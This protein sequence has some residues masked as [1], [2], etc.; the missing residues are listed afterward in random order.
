MLHLYTLNINYFE[1][2]IDK[3]ND[4]WSGHSVSPQLPTSHRQSTTLQL[5]YSDAFLNQREHPQIWHYHF[6]LKFIHQLI[7]CYFSNDEFNDFHMSTIENDMRDYLS[8]KLQLFAIASQV[9]SLE[10]VPNEEYGI[11]KTEI[12][13]PVITT[14]FFNTKSNISQFVIYKSKAWVKL[15]RRYMREQK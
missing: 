13:L 7:L 3:T 4:S 2:H 5:N 12:C 8:L 15:K 11:Y 6:Y 1:I 9:Y 14:N 10:Q